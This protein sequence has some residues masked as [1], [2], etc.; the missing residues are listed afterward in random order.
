MALVRLMRTSGCGGAQDRPPKEPT[1]E[2]AERLVYPCVGYSGSLVWLLYTF[3]LLKIK[4][5]PPT[6]PRRFAIACDDPGKCIPLPNQIQIVQLLSNYESKARSLTHSG[7]RGEIFVACG[8]P[9][10]AAA[11]SGG[12]S[13][14]CGGGNKE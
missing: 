1:I 3:S 2:L 10:L 8:R 9:R 6:T 13:T 14:G 5:V 7:R 11:Y 12:M 4:L